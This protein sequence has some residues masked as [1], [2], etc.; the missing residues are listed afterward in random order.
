MYGSGAT[1]LL[2]SIINMFSFRIKEESDKP[3]ILGEAEM[4]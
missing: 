2:L 3:S 4:R 1:T